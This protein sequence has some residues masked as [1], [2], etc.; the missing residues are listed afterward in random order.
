M[1]LAPLTSEASNPAIFWTRG[2]WCDESGTPLS[3]PFIP[4]CLTSFTF[5]SLLS[6]EPN[7]HSSKSSYAKM[8][9]S[10]I[11][12]AAIVLGLPVLCAAFLLPPDLHLTKAV[13]QS[14]DPGSI[15][16]SVGC[17]GCNWHKDAE[18]MVGVPYQP[19]LESDLVRLTPCTLP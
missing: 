3:I 11:P 2:K 12:L 5:I 15:G 14:V 1:Y 18:D 17:A 19:G 6:S 7:I 13:P 10:S 9:V 8:R 16:V 4:P